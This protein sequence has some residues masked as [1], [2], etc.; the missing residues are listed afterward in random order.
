MSDSINHSRFTRLNKNQY[1]INNPDCQ[2]R[3]YVHTGQIMNYL[4]FD[5][6]LREGKNLADFPGIPLG[7]VDFAIAFNSGTR[8][9][10]KRQL[11]TCITTH[12]GDHITRSDNPVYLQDFHI[13]QE[14]CGLKAPRRDGPTEAQ[15]L[16]NEQFAAGQAI[17]N[18][19]RTE[20]Y[21]QR[22]EKRNTLFKKP[23]PIKDYKS[24]R[25]TPYS[26]AADKTTKVINLSDD[27]SSFGAFDAPPRAVTQTTTAATTSR[28]KG[29]RNQQTSSSKQPSS[30]QQPQQSS[31]SKQSSSSQQPKHPSSQRTQQ[32]SSSQQYKQPS[33]QQSQHPSFHHS[34]SSQPSR[35]TFLTPPVELAPEDFNVNLNDPTVNLPF[36]DSS[37]N[38]FQQNNSGDNMQE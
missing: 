38:G 26:K 29:R 30:S 5:K 1:V 13:T 9:N 21:Q 6:Y 18:Q 12:N 10:D 19:R 15:I 7:Y 8:P 14:Q 2:H 31:S 34:S 23:E 3:W 33:S 35:E 32:S 27:D 4:A 17:K 16:I 25:F 11:S 22:E 36:G 24:N 37:S 28:I 20:Q